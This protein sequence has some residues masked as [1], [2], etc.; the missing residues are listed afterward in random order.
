MTA[1]R[2]IERS[3]ALAMLVAVL[4]G[5]SGRVAW[6][7]GTLQ[8]E[9]P[10]VSHSVSLVARTDRGRYLPDGV[11]RLCAYLKNGGGAPVYIDRRMFWTGFGGGLELQIRDATGKHLPARLMSDAIMP[12][13][14]EDDAS[15][16]IRLDP[17]FFYGTSVTLK[18][19]DFFPKPGTYSLRVVYKSWLRRESVAPQ[20]R[21]LPAIWETAPEMVSEAV[22]IEVIK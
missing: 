20:L 22:S 17:G 5:T 9:R 12:P 6:P 1:S 8:E 11:L 18:V 4:C 7:Q 21:D 14:E 10:S 15:I 2:Q 3:F 13:P 16:L 19:K